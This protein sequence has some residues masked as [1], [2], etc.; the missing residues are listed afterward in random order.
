MFRLKLS[1][2]PEFNHRMVQP[3]WHC[4]IFNHLQPL[5]IAAFILQLTNHDGSGQVGKAKYEK[6]ENYKSTGRVMVE[7]DME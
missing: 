2:T 4:D 6:V 7:R 3:S 5:L 1:M